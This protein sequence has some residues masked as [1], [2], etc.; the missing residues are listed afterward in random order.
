[1]YKTGTRLITEERISW[2]PVPVFYFPRLTTRGY[3][4]K[5]CKKCSI[6]KE[7][8]EFYKNKSNTDGYSSSCKRCRKIQVNM[9]RKE[10]HIRFITNKN[11]WSSCKRISMKEDNKKKAV[12]Y[13]GGK[14]I[15]CGYDEHIAA[16]EFHHRDP[17]KKYYTISTKLREYSFEDL[18]NELDKCDLLCSNCHKIL[19][20]DEL[21]DR[22]NKFRSD[23]EVRLWQF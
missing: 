11:K 21:I 18:K 17:S 7:L 12:E 9:W 8:S 4:K 15:K 22:R 3:M 13:L 5:L 14:C 20:Y 19:H 2:P 23:L 16:L 10:N 1:M 6:E